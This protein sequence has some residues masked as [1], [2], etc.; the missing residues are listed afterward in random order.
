MKESYLRDERGAMTPL[1]LVLFIGILVSSGIA[2][3]LAR[4]ESER[5]D[6]QDALDRGV[7]AA[8]AITQQVDAEATVREYLKNRALSNAELN[9]SITTG[10]K[11]NSRNVVASARYDM[12]TIFF[13][14]VGLQTLPV[15]AKSGAQQVRQPIEI[16]LVLDISGTMR[17]DRRLVNL[18]PAAA[19]FVDNVTD[20]GS[21]SLTTINLIPYAGQVNPGPEV[22]AILN[23][24]RD[25]GNSSCLEFGA[26]D[27][28]DTHLPAAPSYGQVPN[29][30]F[31]KI[32]RGWMDW[33]WCPSD[34]T[35]ITYLSTNA[36]ALKHAINDIRLHDGTGTYNAMKWALALLDPASQPFVARLAADG[37]VDREFSSRPD[38]W[39]SAETKKF[40]VLMTDGI[41]TEQYRPINP[42]DPAIK[43][44]EVLV[45]NHRHRQTLSRADGLKYFYGLCDM[46]K[47]NGV[48]VFTISFE[49]PSAAQEEMRN[50]AS[51]AGHYYNV[52][53][54][55]IGT[56]FDL[57]ASTIGRLKLVE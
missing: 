17:W 23:G 50:C 38:A 18:R 32:D 46:A 49:A 3:D 27:F 51:S 57:I 15:I 54:S 21:D 45:Y 31:W 10:P 37:I 55:E 2:L 53:G 19:A 28:A 4:H 36:N 35:A 29:F 47:K 25:H 56:A 11:A 9:I 24:R 13:R 6:L 52:E 14:L 39:D 43:T 41:I 30:H 33:G 1:M 16:S 26:Q 48:T 34:K 22:F 42:R 40:I 8:T 44:E 20:G 12:D 5:S 7:L